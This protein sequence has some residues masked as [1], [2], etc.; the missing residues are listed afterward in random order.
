MTKKSRPGT[1]IYGSAGGLVGAASAV[2]IS[3]SGFSALPTVPEQPISVSSFNPELLHAEVDAANWE[4]NISGVLRAAMG[5]AVKSTTIE[6]GDTLADVLADAGLDNTTSYNVAQAMHPVFNPRY[7]RAGQKIDLAYDAIGV[8]GE[9]LALS[10]VSME[11]S[12]GHTVSVTRQ[13]DGGFSAEEIIAETYSEFARAT[14]TISSSLYEEAVNQGVPLDV[15]TAMVRLFSYDVD[16]QR[17]IQPGDGFALMYEQEVTEDGRAV[18]TN[19]I[20]LAEMT[21][22]GKSLKFYAFQHEDGDYGYYNEKGEGVRKALMRTPVNGARLTSGFGSRR[23]PILGF[24][25]MHKGV[26]FGAPTGT[27]IMAAGDGVIEKRGRWGSYGHYVRIRHG[28]N[29][30]TA[31]AHLSRY[32]RGINV[33]TRVKQGEIIGYVGSTG[34]STGPHLH[35]EVLSNGKQVNPMTIK[36]PASKKLN[37]EQLQAF[38]KTRAQ[39]EQKFASLAIPSDIAMIETKDSNTSRE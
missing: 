31:Y 36:F 22:R 19:A 16:F 23:H 2:M 11:I 9:P 38:Q 27:P 5:L 20:H 25:R 35:Y 30:A 8:N 3:T 15:L 34:R 13:A 28:S 10:R 29:Y 33:G 37:G 18:R 39:A 4:E 21:L 24:T 26:D 7:L 1:L 17:D 14:G 6:R 12:P 32:A